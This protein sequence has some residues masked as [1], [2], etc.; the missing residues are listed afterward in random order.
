MKKSIILGISLMA[1]VL[2][3][4]AAPGVASAASPVTRVTGVINHDGQPVAGAEVTAI[5][6]AA[7][8]TDVT[9][10]EGSYLATF[11]ATDCPLGSVAQIKA[12]KGEMSGSASGDVQGVS[13][14]LNTAV[15]NA[16]LPEYGL[17]G[18]L[19]A[20]AAGAGVIAFSRRRHAQAV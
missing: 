5:C 16:S 4:S 1:F 2:A 18:S 10:A 9:D 19:V 12:K 14:R 3:V 17:I 11:A 13:T 20:V 8:E 7:T 6:G 15:V